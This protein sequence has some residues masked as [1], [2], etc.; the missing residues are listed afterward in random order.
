MRVDS[1]RATVRGAFEIIEE[2]VH[3]LRTCP[4]AAW[5]AYC[6][7][8]LP[9]ILGLLVFWS[10]MSRSPVANR[11]LP[12]ASFALA[13]LFLWMKCWQTIFLRALRK[14]LTHGPPEKSQ[15][16]KVARWI[17]VQCTLQ[18]IGLF[19][20]P[21]SILIVLPFP[22]V[23]CFFQNLTVL[24]AGASGSMRE[25]VK[26]AWQQSSLWPRQLILIIVF[27]A[28]FAFFVFLNWNIVGYA[29][30]G[31]IKSLLGIE[32]VYARSGISI[33]NTTFFAIMAGLTYLCVDPIFKAAFLLRCFYGESLRTGEDLKAELSA[34]SVEAARFAA[35][36]VLTLF[37]I[38]GATVTAAER[39]S[40]PE[41]ASQA[42]AASV[43]A[44]ELDKA[45]QSVINQSKYTWR[46]QREF[47]VPDETANKGPIGR[48]LDR[49]RTSI[50]RIAVKVWNWTLDWLHRF[51]RN[52]STNKSG[53]SG[54]F[55]WM[56]WL[57]VLLYVLIIIIVVA[58]LYLLYRFFDRRARRASS[59]AAQPI[60]T[61]PDL[62]DE[63]V[64]ADQ[65]EED[66]WLV[67]AKDLVARGDLRL[68]MRAFYFSSLA[69]LA[70]RNLISLATYKSNRDYEREIL[71]RSHALPQLTALFGENVST[72]DRIWYGLHDVN[73]ELTTRFAANVEKINSNT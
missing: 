23:Y 27:L 7:G 25:C 38:Q 12:G 59:V 42:P 53:S 70:K 71:R 55:G 49:V 37:L 24:S 73:M 2:A 21:L 30:P 48:F 28:L 67:M 3:L 64:G 44:P 18:P 8:T 14:S 40:S 20:L 66:V 68:A 4:A 61:V 35:L 52:L 50:K 9:F 1:E 22:W 58:A 57:Q 62:S 51:N 69:H 36:V 46:M 34:L 54:G 65:L 26:K 15:F 45:I 5:A 16:S 56:M 32:S 47:L 60:Q 33:L 13:L 10:D 41:P 17:L 43:S 63:N 39:D 19:L 72:F 29:L 6:L 11:H 31:L